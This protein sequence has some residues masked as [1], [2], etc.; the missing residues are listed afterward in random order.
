MQGQYKSYGQL[1][2]VVA[3]NTIIPILQ[4]EQNHL[5]GWLIFECLFFLACSFFLGSAGPHGIL[6]I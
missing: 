6:V 3:K 1:C 4:S 2:M 5:S